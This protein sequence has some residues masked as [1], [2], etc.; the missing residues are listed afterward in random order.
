MLLLNNTLC[1]CVY[2]GR[3][4]LRKYYNF[5]WRSFPKDH[6]ITHVKFAEL[7]KLD[8]DLHDDIIAAA[9]EKGNRMILDICVIGICRDVA[10]IEYCSIVEKLINN[11][12]LSKIMKVFKNGQC[13]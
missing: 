1:I 6:L 8:K 7:F 11:P 5:L 2:V 4:L 3:I 13:A 9:P 12:K 10:L